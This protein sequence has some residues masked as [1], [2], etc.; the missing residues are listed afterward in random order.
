MTY[1]MSGYRNYSYV[2]RSDYSDEDGVDCSLSSTHFLELSE[3]YCSDNH[4]EYIGSVC[5][6]L[7]HGCTR[8]STSF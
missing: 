2:S 3:S 7:N 8:F 6:D 1:L 5:N 4:R